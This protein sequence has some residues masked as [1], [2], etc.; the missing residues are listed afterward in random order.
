MLPYA[1]GLAAKPVATDVWT[2]GVFSVLIIFGGISYWVIADIIRTRSLRKLSL[3]TKLVLSAFII[4]IVAGTAVFFT[5]EYTNPQTMG[6]MS[7]EDKALT[8]VFHSVS[9]RTA[10][11]QTLSFGDTQ[12]QT[13]F[14]YIGLMFV[15]AASASVGGGIKV[16]TFMV[17]L[18]AVFCTLTGKSRTTAFQ[19]EIPQEQVM[20]AM[21]IGF[22]ALVYVFASAFVLSFL[23]HEARFITLFF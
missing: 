17:I 18:I 7:I 19:R 6:Q 14:F 5:A 21:G 9:S 12:Q 3:N 15:G 20:R 4:L 22:V 1:E 16:N 10:G 2:L 11:M 23:E 13:N 8:S